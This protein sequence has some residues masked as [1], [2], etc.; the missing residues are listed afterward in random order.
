[1]GSLKRFYNAILMLTVIG[2]VIWRYHRQW[3]AYL[4]KLDPPRYRV[5]VERGIRIPMRDGVLLSADHYAPTTPLRVPALL[6]RSPYG[7]NAG[8]SLFGLLLEFFG[9]RFAER[10]YHVLIQDTRGRFDSGG[11]FNPYFNENQ[12]GAATLDW[13]CRQAW[14]TGVIG[15]WGGS[16]LGI[17]Q[18]LVAADNPAVKA[19]V[20]SI[21]STQL[22]K[23]LYPDGALDLGLSL[24]WLSLFQTLDRRRRNPLRWFTVL[25][26]VER[27]IQPA[28]LNLPLED[29]DEIVLGER[30]DAFH[31][32]IEF[33]RAD[34]AIWQNNLDQMRLDEITAPT[35]LISGWYDFFLRGLLDDYT[36]LTAAGR[37]PYLTIGAWHHFSAIIS[38]ADLREGLRWFDAHLRGEPN[39]LRE[40][41]VRLF[42]MGANEW[43]DYDTFPPPAVETRYHLQSAWALSMS[44]PHDES[45]PDLYSYDPT[46]PTPAVGGAIF[47]VKGGRVDNR[48][49]EARDD[50]LTYTTSPLRHPVEVIG[51]VRVEL[52]AQSDLEHTDFFGRL[53]DVY[54]DGR[55]FNLCEGL[56]RL[57]PGKLERQADGTMCVEIDLWATAHVFKRG[58]A[59]RLQISSG[60]HPHWNRNLGTGEYFG[61][62]CTYRVAHQTVF[63]DKLRPS[64][65][66]LPVT[67]PN[68]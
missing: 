51:R 55:S 19:L 28:L 64:A 1:V 49:L 22:H 8:H 18:W 21:T 45:Q 62:C 13:L 26:D 37:A 59:I 5:T 2:L 25:H 10:G 4:L 27:A 35:H 12:D 31:Q 11:A 60:A 9:H 30:A 48:A 39:R 40:K 43:R 7:R 36:T 67:L 38:M 41:P 20:P 16:Y 23:I 42:V 32:W 15:L 24:R 68:A 33:D 50:V 56:F 58:H 57:Q 14:S 52:Y 44:L 54:P 53:C 63:H 29:A 66:I 61:T 65:L 46:D 17:V 3:L 34:D 6:I 47:S